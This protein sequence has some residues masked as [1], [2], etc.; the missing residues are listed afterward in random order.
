MHAGKKKVI[1]KETTKD[2]TKE[3]KGLIAKLS[4][5]TD[6]GNSEARRI[7]KQLRRLGHSISKTK[8]K[9][10]VKSKGKAIAKVVKKKKAT[11]AAP[12]KKKVSKD[13]EDG[14]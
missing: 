7:R 2:N 9:V 10:V 13:K 11:K 3:I 12:R 5:E 14:K 6:S 8:E 1:K 4:K